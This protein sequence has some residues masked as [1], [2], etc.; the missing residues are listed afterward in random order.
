MGWVA[1]KPMSL[2]GRLVARGE[3]VPEADAWPARLRSQRIEHEWIAWRDDDIDAAHDDPTQV[4]R[5]P[6]DPPSAKTGTGGG[7]FGGVGQR[8]DAP[9]RKRGRR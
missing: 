2:G 5:P 6:M 8:S 9:R 1:I 3:A 7:S 4:A